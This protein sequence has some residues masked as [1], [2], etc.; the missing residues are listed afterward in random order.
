MARLRSKPEPAPAPLQ[1][2]LLAVPI[3]VPGIGTG[4]G[5]LVISKWQLSPVLTT[6]LIGV[7]NEV[8]LGLGVVVVLRW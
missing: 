2:A 5:T 4:H 8:A 3:A 7:R 1:A 6:L